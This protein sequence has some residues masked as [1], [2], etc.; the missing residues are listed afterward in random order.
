MTRK[1]YIFKLHTRKFT[2]FEIILL[3]NFEYIHIYKKRITEFNSI[4]KLIL[5]FNRKIAKHE[6]NQLVPANKFF[7]SSL[8]L[9]L[10]I[11]VLYL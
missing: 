6:M 3:C 1:N 8:F 10:L 9:P 5:F 4:F 2:L 11:I 7:N